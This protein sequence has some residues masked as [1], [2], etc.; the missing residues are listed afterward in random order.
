MKKLVEIMADHRLVNINPD[1][2]ESVETYKGCSPD[3]FDYTLTMASGCQYN[4]T[5]ATYEHLL[6]VPASRKV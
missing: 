4:I 5:K 2:V 3:N 6:K 1:L